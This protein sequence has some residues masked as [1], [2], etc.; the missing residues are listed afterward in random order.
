MEYIDELIMQNSY[1]AP[2]YITASNMII[3]AIKISVDSLYNNLV[4]FTTI[5][6]NLLTIALTNGSCALNTTYFIAKQSI[7]EISDIMRNAM[8]ECLWTYTD[9]ILFAFCVYNLLRLVYQN[10]KLNYEAKNLNSEIEQL[11]KNISYIKKT[12]RMREDW[13][14]LWSEEIRNYYNEHNNKYKELNNKYKEL[15]KQVKKINKEVN[16]YN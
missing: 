11:Q 5:V 7:I 6:I 10:Y 12:E 14:Q 16:Q 8:N 9:K 4:E 3:P 2:V 1:V 15:N 13:E